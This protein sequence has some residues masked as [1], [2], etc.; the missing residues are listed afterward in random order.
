MDLG[1]SQAGFDVVFSND[2]NP[3]VKE[4]YNRNHSCRLDIR[5][6]ADVSVFHIPPVSGFIGGP[7]CQ[8]WSLIGYMK[9]EDDSRGK[10]F[11]EYI[12]LLELCRPDF[13]VAENVPGIVSKTHR[14]AWKRIVHKFHEVGYY[15]SCVL[16]DA[17]GYG[18]P[19]ERKRV[20]AVGY[21]ENLVSR[22]DGQFVFPRS[23]EK[24]VTLRD[25]IG[26]MPAPL[27]VEPNSCHP[28]GCLSLPNHEYATG[29]FS[30]RFLTRNRRRGWDEVSFTIQASAR[31]CPIH[32]GSPP[33]FKVA[34]GQWSLNDSEFPFTRDDSGEVVYGPHNPVKARRFSVR[35]CARIQSFPDDF[36]FF[37]SKVDD[38]YKMVGNAVPVKLAEAIARNIRRD[39][40]S[41]AYKESSA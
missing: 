36:E 34:K 5:S 19:Q 11:Y 7:P 13:F 6:I 14:E 33:M 25:A 29:G 39:L 8:S 15:V 40:E 37:Y 12:R 20:I 21:S 28:P 38:G 24:V 4:T 18:V 1:F 10:L 2:V 30:P 17:S 26:D 22:L 35:E 27:P 41:C 31:H 32:P 23:S 9:G 3:S 16:L